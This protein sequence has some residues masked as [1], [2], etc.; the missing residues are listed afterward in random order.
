M[1]RE[2]IAQ[3]PTP[4]LQSLYLYLTGNC[5]LS[6]QHCWV[7]PGSANNNDRRP[8]SLNLL[9]KTIDQA[10]PLGLTSVKLTGGEP[11]F[12]PEIKDI[13]SLIENYQLYLNIESNGVLI[14]PELEKRL[15]K[16][17]KFQ[18][19]SISLDGSTSTTHDEIRGHK[20]AFDKTVKIIRSLTE[21]GLRPQVIC[22]LHKKNIHEIH[23][24]LDMAQEEKWSSIKFN[25]VQKIGRGKSFVSRYGLSIEE[26]IS[27]YHQ[28]E[29][30]KQD[31]KTPIVFDIP[32]AFRSIRDLLYSVNGHCT[33]FNIL[34]ILSDNSWSLCGIGE[35]V[36]ELVFGHPERND[37]KDIWNNHPKLLEL[38]SKIPDHLEGVCEKCIFKYSC[39]G[40]CVA[41]NYSLCNQFNAPYHFCSNAEKLGLFPVSAL[42][43]IKKGED[44]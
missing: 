16:Y 3:K 27:L 31:I 11:F 26:I 7:S 20:G 15:I 4:S 41:N 43:L 29:K 19:I 42:N 8:M 13:L 34:G 37:L 44:K 12:H 18:F 35:T 1:N 9:Q 10:M 23:S 36:P 24:F 22:T 17:S 38:R 40:H 39:K 30:Y 32:I 21:A 5:N 25:L 28:I 14:N 33:V 6:C 2:K